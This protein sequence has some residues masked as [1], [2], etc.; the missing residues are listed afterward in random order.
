MNFTSPDFLLLFLPLVFTG[1]F[2][3]RF[4]N[5]FL[6]KVFIIVCSAIFYAWMEPSW[7]LI[8]I[9]SLIFNFLIFL[10]LKEKKT[11]P[12][13]LFGIAVNLA[14]L[15]FYKYA[16]FFASEFGMNTAGLPA[17]LPIGISF[18]TFQQIAFLVDSYQQK[19]KN[20]TWENYAFFIAFFPQLIAGPIMH[21]REIIPQLAEKKAFK[22]SWQ[23]LSLGIFLISMG[24]FKKLF[25]ADH[26]AIFADSIFESDGLVSQSDA[27]LGTFAYT[28][29]IYFDFSGYTDMALGLGSLFGI[30]LAANF[31]SPY[32]ST[33]FQDFWRRWHIT[34]SAFFR[35]YLYIPLGGNR[36]ETFS[37]H[38][39]NVLFVMFLCGVWH[40]A[41]WGFIVWG[42]LHGL[43]LC[44]QILWVKW[45]G[46]KHTSQEKLLGWF[47]TFMCISLSWVFFRAETLADA[48]MIFQALFNFGMG[49]AAENQIPFLYALKWLGFASLIAF[50]MPNSVEITQ[51][52]LQAFVQT[53]A[54][55]QSL[56]G[57]LQW[58][59]NYYW[60]C[61]AGFMFC[62]SFNKLFSPQPFL[63]FQF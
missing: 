17:V 33:S 1:F 13:L 42:V 52:S 35:D 15:F 32:K 63:Y 27:W 58:M 24:F 14:L 43:F 9:F 11:K 22:I 26:L 60:L 48:S 20:V 51:K 44:A 6:V 25:L 21:H 56:P 38:L 19:T 23:S 41:G 61:L 30:R 8:L 57:R 28:F 7:L 59:P 40:G 49:Q 50:F 18:F 16:Y 31:L 36:T 45:I 5:D 3:L 39:F 47:V 55:V 12:L 2:F 54:Q 34:L 10:V 4:T 62:L 37:R 46:L 53:K 29:Q